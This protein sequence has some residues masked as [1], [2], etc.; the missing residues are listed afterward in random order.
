MLLFSALL[1]FVVTLALLWI[2]RPLAIRLDLLDKP[3]GRKQHEGDIPLIGGIAIVLGFLVGL[4][5]LSTSLITLRPYLLGLMILLVVGVL[6]DLHELTPRARLAAQLLA[7][8]LVMVWGQTLLV[9]IGHIGIS[10]MSH[11]IGWFAWPFSCIAIVGTINAINMLDGVDGQASGVSLIAL[12]A[13]VF[14]A[15]HADKVPEMMILLLMTMAT[16]AFACLNIPWLHSRSASVFMGDAGSMALGFTLV[17]FCLRLSQPPVSAFMPAIILW[18]L[19]VPVSDIIYVTL[20]RLSKG[21]S[22]LSA[23]RDHIHHLLLEWG[24]TPRQT[25]VI[26]LLLG[27]IGATVAIMATVY[28][29]HD[30]RL[31]WGFILWLLLYCTVVPHAWRRLRRT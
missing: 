29:W 6:D 5:T 19:I 22:P 12:A 21:R 24:C 15:Y 26:S 23:G 25:L 11:T 3:G 1:T 13:M 18:L 30:N 16:A 20:M 17:Y 28:Q 2:L 7:A 27:A 10:G 8:L 14:L 31:F 9:S 4:L